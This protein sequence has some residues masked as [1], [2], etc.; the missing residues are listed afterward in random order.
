MWDTHT[1]KGILCDF[2][3]ATLRDSSR[4]RGQE[5]T[6]TVPFMAI[7]LLVRDYFDGKIQRLYR[8]D[9]ESFVWVLIWAS[10][11]DNSEW[12]NQLWNTSNYDI[13]YSDKLAFLSQKHNLVVPTAKEGDRWSLVLDLVKW[14]SAMTSLHDNTLWDKGPK[15]TYEDVMAI[16]DNRWVWGD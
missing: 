16:I 4:K 10:M 6:G 7:D 12:E 13:C 8:H 2:D 11:E 5:R 1:Q 3:L 15:E 14:V 9:L